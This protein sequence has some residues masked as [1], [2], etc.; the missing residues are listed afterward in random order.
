MSDTKI[1][2]GAGQEG[3]AA[4]ALEPTESNNTMHYTMTLRHPV[5]RPGDDLLIACVQLDLSKLTGAN[6]KRAATMASSDDPMGSTAVSPAYCAACL[7]FCMD[8]PIIIDDLVGPD[9]VELT[10]VVQ[11][12]LFG[13]PFAQIQSE[14][15]NGAA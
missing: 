3:E 11:R 8:N 5:K 1:E 2:T 13:L 10:L 6:L 4:V 14:S 12:F 7:E 15:V 9:F